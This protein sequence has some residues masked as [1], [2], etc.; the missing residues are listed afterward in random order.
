[1]IRRH[2]GG[3]TIIETMM[4][5][6]VSGALLASTMGV[7]QGKQERTLFTQ[8]I[9]SYELQLKDIMNDV[10]TGYYP[11]D[12]T[13]T[14][15]T[16]ASTVIFTIGS[17]ERGTQSCLY[18]G[19][20]VWMPSGNSFASY[21]MVGATQAKLYE[22]AFDLSLLSNIKLLGY[23]AN[24]GPVDLRNLS[25]DVTITKI[26]SLQDSRSV[27]GIAVISN[28]SQNVGTASDP[29]LQGNAAQISV[30]EVLGNN[31]AINSFKNN[32]ATDSVRPSTNGVAICLQQ[33][34]SN[35]RKA[36]VTVGGNSQKLSTEVQIDTDCPA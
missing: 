33:G 35:G 3:Y 36:V 4:F 7:I 10:S 29:T 27:S 23:A 17:K 6:V 2:C 30:Y 26:V 13:F 8:S 21:T 34:G 18:L 32:G 9:D 16:T 14:C 19:K 20:L 12:E 5:L 11:S 22:T 1:M 25:A 24:P 28:F 15:T 31:L